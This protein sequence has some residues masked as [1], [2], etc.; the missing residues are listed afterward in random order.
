MAQ[1]KRLITESH[2]RIT[3]LHNLAHREVVHY[4]VTLCTARVTRSSKIGT[5]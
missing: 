2:A 1:S 5:I 3:T 4:E